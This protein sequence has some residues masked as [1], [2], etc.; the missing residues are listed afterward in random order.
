MKTGEETAAANFSLI[1]MTPT[2]LQGLTYLQF[3]DGREPTE[4]VQR[5][6]ESSWPLI[7]FGESALRILPG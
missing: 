7:C 4:E 3:A 2:R 5:A 6:S 1:Y